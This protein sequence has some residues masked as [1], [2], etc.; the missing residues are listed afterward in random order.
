MVLPVFWLRTPLLRGALLLALAL[1]LLV[2][3]G[4]HA[5][6]ATNNS[7][8]VLGGF[9]PQ[10]ASISYDVFNRSEV[11]CGGVG[12][13]SGS[14]FVPG[15]VVH[16]NGVPVDTYYHSSTSME[17]N[18]CLAP[19]PN[20]EDHYWTTRSDLR[21]P[22][23]SAANPAPVVLDVTVV[24]PG[25]GGGESNSLPYFIT[26]P[27]VY[28]SG[29]VTRTSANGGL[30]YDG[31]L[32]NDGTLSATATGNG[33]ISFG[34][35]TNN[36]L[37]GERDSAGYFDIYVGPGSAFSTISMVVCDSGQAVAVLAMNGQSGPPANISPDTP[38][39]GCATVTMD[40]VS[41]PTTAQLKGT[42]FGA[43]KVTLAYVKGYIDRASADKGVATAL[44]A[45]VDGIAAAPNAQA[46]AG[47][48]RA[49]TN[50]VNAQTGK[51]LTARQAKA[52][53]A[54]AGML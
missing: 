23:P 29:Y 38:R 45:E 50:D 47:K 7:V 11:G 8:P 46:K 53:I 18:G 54:F 27:E 3:L 21:V 15:S 2:P 1:A 36:P 49:F 20:P 35:Y 51:A 25:P 5:D 19:N 12:Q 9:Y 52:L 42:P 17:A 22:L 41:W 31:R 13:I 40:N 30:T 16:V 10:A 28:F 32:S 26:R 43:G 33:T 44:K 24:N 39:P 6:T 34:N 14:G 4:V 37:T 48:L